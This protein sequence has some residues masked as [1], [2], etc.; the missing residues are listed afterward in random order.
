[1]SR[2]C[3]PSPQPQASGTAAATAS[4]GTPTNTP[5]RSRSVAELCSG[6]TSGSGVRCAPGPVLGGPAT[7]V[8][9][10]AVMVGPRSARAPRAGKRSSAGCLVAGVSRL[11]LPSSRTGYAYVTVTYETVSW[12]RGLLRFHQ[13][14]AHETSAGYRMV[15]HYEISAVPSRRSLGGCSGMAARTFRLPGE[16]SNLG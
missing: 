9:G 13:E 5:T 15:S 4:S 10:T 8:S 1:M 6:S 16:D 11:W 2:S 3:Q 14:V 12:A 7:R